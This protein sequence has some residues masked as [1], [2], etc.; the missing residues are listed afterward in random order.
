MI[1]LLKDV[2]TVRKDLSILLLISVII[3]GLIEFVFDDIPEIFKGG[4]K[5]GIIFENLSL[6]YIAGFIFYFLT[7]H[8]KAEK[9]KRNYN[10]RIGYLTF[11]IITSSDNMTSDIVSYGQ[12]GRIDYRED[13][14][15]D[16]CSRIDVFKKEAINWIDGTKGDW[17]DF[18]YSYMQDT[19]SD[20]K[21]L[22]D[23]LIYLEPEHSKLIGRI[24]DSIFLK[25]INAIYHNRAIITNGNLSIFSTDIMMYMNLMNDLKKYADNNL[26]A[27]RHLTGSSIGYIRKEY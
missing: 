7:I 26:S 16:A 1:T 22:N 10:E 3:I 12:S 4:H 18:L 27:Y 9:D 11:D 2:K 14:I 8:L 19:K 25:K 21:A 6:S 15:F 5:L 20:I 23:R 17:L 13:L 24:E